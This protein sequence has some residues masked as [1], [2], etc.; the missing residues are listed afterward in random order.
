MFSLCALTELSNVLSL[1]TYGPGGMPL[2]DRMHCIQARHRSRDLLEWVFAHYQF[3]S[4]ADPPVTLDP[5]MDVYWPYVVRVVRGLLIYKDVA[6]EDIEDSVSGCTATAVQRQ[7]KMCFEGV[8][9]Y[10]QSVSFWDNQ[11][12]QTLAWP[13]RDPKYAFTVELRATPNPRKREYIRIMIVY[14]YY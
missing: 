11:T 6:K 7:I 10:A 12:I 14:H 13:T 4:T 8:T 9:E 5:K 2:E 3:K 1:Q